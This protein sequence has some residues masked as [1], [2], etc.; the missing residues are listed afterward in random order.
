[1]ELINKNRRDIFK[2]TPEFLSDQS[3]S[4]EWLLKTEIYFDH[5]GYLFDICEED[6]LKDLITVTVFYNTTG[7]I[8]VNDYEHLLESSV[9]KQLTFKFKL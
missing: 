5:T 4:L 3:L 7:F 9:K 8:I 6:R 1:M 2:V